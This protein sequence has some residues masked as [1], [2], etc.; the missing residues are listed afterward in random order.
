MTDPADP[1]A[2]KFGTMPAIP[3][4]TTVAGDVI[5]D[6]E[7]RDVSSMFTQNIKAPFNF[8]AATTAAGDAV[9]DR[10]DRPDDHRQA[11]GVAV[12]RDRVAPRSG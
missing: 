2:G 9:A 12:D 4:G 8:I 10:Q 11:G 3:A 7:R 5:L 6:T 1:S